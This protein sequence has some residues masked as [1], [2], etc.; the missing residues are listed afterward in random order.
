MIR[1]CR[2]PSGQ[3]CDCF[4]ACVPP[5]GSPANPDSA[6]FA[7]AVTPDLISTSGV[8]WQNQT[9]EVVVSTPSAALAAGPAPTVTVRAPA[10]LL[11][12]AGAG[13]PNAA[14]L[15]LA[16][17]TFQVE[18][19]RRVARQ[20]VTVGPAAGLS[21][22][23][24]PWSIDVIGGPRIERRTSVLIASTTASAT[25]TS[26]VFKGEVATLDGST[27]GETR[28]PVT[29]WAS[30]T[31]V[32]LFDESRVL[33]PS[34]RLGVPLSG[35][36]T[37]NLSWI[38]N[39]TSTLS[40][41]VKLA[42]APVRSTVGDL[43]GGQFQ[44]T[45]PF[46]VQET[47]RFQFDLVRQD[48]LPA[49][50]ACTLDAQCGATAY[51][52]ESLGLCV[53]GAD[54]R[55]ATLANN[56]A[57][58][59]GDEWATAAA[60]ML[61]SNTPGLFGYPTIPGPRGLGY[62]LGCFPAGTR[63]Y[64]AP[65]SYVPGFRHKAGM[66]VA[67]VSGEP[68]GLDVCA[69]EVPVAL[70]RDRAIASPWSV[71]LYGSSLLDTCLQEL[72]ATPPTSSATDVNSRANAWFAS[73]NTCVSPSRFYPMWSWLT[74]G[75]W[76]RH[77]GGSEARILHHAL[78]RWLGSHSLLAMQSTAQDE[79]DGA[80]YG[81]TEPGAAAR[82]TRSIGAIE[83]AFDLLLTARTADAL[84]MLPRDV[85]RKPDYRDMR[86]VS[87]YTFDAAD[88]N[89][90]YV[91]D[92]AGEAHTYLPLTYAR[93]GEAISSASDQSIVIPRG[94]AELLGE[95]SIGVFLTIP[96]TTVNQKKVIVEYGDAS[97]LIYQ[98]YFLGN[99]SAQPVLYA[100][101]GPR[102]STTGAV[103]LTGALVAGQQAHFLLSRTVDYD[104]SSG[105]VPTWRTTYRALKDGILQGSNICTNPMITSL[106]P[107]SSQG[108]YT[109]RGTVDELTYWDEAVDAWFNSSLFMDR[110]RDNAQMDTLRAA[111]AYPIDSDHVQLDSVAPAA[112]ELA[113]QYLRTVAHRLESQV[114]SIYAECT[115][116]A[117]SSSARSAAL[118]LHGR[119]QRYS[120]AVEMLAARMASRATTTGCG[121]STSVCA[122]GQTCTLV[123]TE[124]VCAIGGVPVT[125]PVAWQSRYDDA[126]REL[127]AARGVLARAIQPAVACEDPYGVPH[128]ALPLFFGDVLGTSSRFFA[129]SDYLVGTWALPAVAQASASL[130]AARDAWIQ[131]RSSEIQ[132]LTTNYE[133]QER[134]DQLERSYGQQVSDLCGLNSTAVLDV[135]DLFTPGQLSAYSCFRNSSA[136]CS[137]PAGRETA[138]CYRGE[139][140]K[141]GPG[142]L[143]RQAGHRDRAC[144]RPRLGAALREP[145]RVLQPG[146]ST[147][148]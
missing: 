52:E 84:A 68:S 26:G 59:E 64:S 110:S 138:A 120:L 23:N 96:T 128:D 72:E 28:V 51:C 42:T 112:V 76:A 8:T 107:A 21:T 78:N 37:A 5:A 89:G 50:P 41:Q 94:P 82:L 126:R 13:V 53:G 25:P 32:L 102:A 22:A 140:G 79:A 130:E 111:L 103:A 105:F 127:D 139:M 7:L 66:S 16:G 39:T 63:T 11:L 133:K 88:M 54:W 9:F 142:S 141:V 58:A 17:W 98:F 70:G 62:S 90:Q 75:S 125:T 81:G 97:N 136:T 137:T 143:H 29:A 12:R 124:N 27:R 46:A 67:T 35:A 134:L 71:T 40:A 15:T 36:A 6:T 148:R 20:L 123:G 99:A 119:A 30:P 135:L 65:A 34:G 10:G 56:L 44:I 106:V 55:T 45:L 91:L 117:T 109:V 73:S 60:W 61:G 146:A 3:V 118:A 101:H 122:T 104:L 108:S 121:L 132:Q 19:G 147:S 49:G 48:A 18:D 31:F 131:R 93:S 24:A 145:E 83:S 113:A 38:T 69:Q 47:K 86:P 92:V 116:G 129:A 14:E 95:F 114:G 87:Y 2:A 80:V 115:N 100:Y 1:R 33:S 74:A 144:E 77:R 4:G 43:T 57:S 85:L